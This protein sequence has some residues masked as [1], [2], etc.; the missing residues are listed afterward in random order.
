MLQA[1]FLKF[2]LYLNALKDSLLEFLANQ[3]FLSLKILK[4]T[5]QEINH[6]PIKV[7]IQQTWINY[8]KKQTFEEVL[9][10]QLKHV[11]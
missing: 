7:K 9:N 10:K 6:Q 5:Q 3:I 4:E 2:K 8:Q 1:M 11:L